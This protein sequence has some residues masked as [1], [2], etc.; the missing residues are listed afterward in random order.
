MRLVV[1]VIKAD[2]GCADLAVEAGVMPLPSLVLYLL[3]TSKEGLACNNNSLFSF[4]VNISLQI[5][6]FSEYFF[7]DHNFLMF[8]WQR[9]GKMSLT[10]CKTDFSP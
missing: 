5:T 4:L 3:R 6:I 1:D 2:L 7:A 10:K 9:H 8:V